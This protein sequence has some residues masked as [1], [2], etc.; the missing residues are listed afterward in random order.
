VGGKTV[1]FLKTVHSKQAI[2]NGPKKKSAI[3]REG[4]GWGITGK[5]PLS[6]NMDREGSEVGGW[7][8]EETRSPYHPGLNQKIDAQRVREAFKA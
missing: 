7:K 5:D 1:V 6:V 2:K 3:K 4:S 8:K